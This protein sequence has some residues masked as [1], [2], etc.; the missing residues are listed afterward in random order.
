MA[1]DGVP[2]TEI[3]DRATDS[4][5]QDRTTHMCR[6]ILIYTH[7][8][9]NKCMVTNTMINVKTS[10]GM[11]ATVRHVVWVHTLPDNRNVHTSKLKAFA[12]DNLNVI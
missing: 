8:P 10:Y 2:L 6:L 5:E 1:L 11:T 3:N 12:D 4:A 9:Q 7:Y